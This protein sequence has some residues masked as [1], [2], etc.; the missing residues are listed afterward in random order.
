M[1]SW[2][3]YEKSVTGCIQCLRRCALDAQ[4]V[5]EKRQSPAPG[6]KKVYVG[7]MTVAITYLWTVDSFVVSRVKCWKR[8]R[9][10]LG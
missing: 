8:N 1:N 4:F 9:S 7:T 6:T 2:K 3:S 10:Y 5:W